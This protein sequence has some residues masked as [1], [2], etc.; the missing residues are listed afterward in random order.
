MIAIIIGTFG[1]LFI[2]CLL[3]FARI[4]KN[5]L[6]CNQAPP[7]TQEEIDATNECNDNSEMYL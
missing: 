2:I 5:N 1:L 6:I 4:V 7:S 3:I